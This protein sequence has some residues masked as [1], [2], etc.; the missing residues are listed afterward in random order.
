MTF[1]HLSSLNLSRKDG[2]VQRENTCPEVSIVKVD[3]EDK[4]YRQ[5][6]FIAMDCVSNIEEETR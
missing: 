4:A 3:D 6:R 2:S 5:Q 1:H